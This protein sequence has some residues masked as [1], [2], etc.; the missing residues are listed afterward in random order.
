MIGRA[1]LADH[2]AATKPFESGILMI[3]ADQNR[4]S[5][6]GVVAQPLGGQR[7]GEGKARPGE[8]L[9]FERDP[10]GAIAQPRRVPR[11]HHA[12]AEVKMITVGF[13]QVG[14]HHLARVVDGARRLGM[15]GELL[16]DGERLEL[17]LVEAE[18]IGPGRHM[19]ALS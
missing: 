7:D 19:R 2:R 15:A 5:E 17:E 11:P 3:A 10:H 4:S 9:A 6:A 18:R 12:R 1:T 16:Q 8:A 13:R 14:D